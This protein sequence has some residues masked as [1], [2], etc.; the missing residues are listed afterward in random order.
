MNE[1]RR[2]HLRELAKTLPN[3]LDPLIVD[4]AR[5]Y[6]PAMVAENDR[7][8]TENGQ[9]REA[10]AD[11]KEYAVLMKTRIEGVDKPDDGPVA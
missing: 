11:L 6:L 5:Q 10:L 2:A 8:R 4:W 3:E 1:Q 7:L 9:L